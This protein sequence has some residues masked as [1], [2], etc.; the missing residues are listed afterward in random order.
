[1]IVGREDVC[2]TNACDCLSKKLPHDAIV[3]SS[4][5]ASS[6]S[7]HNNSKKNNTSLITQCSSEPTH[8]I[9]NMDTGTT[10]HYFALKDNPILKHVNR[11]TPTEQIQV[12]MPNG[13][14]ITSS[15]TAELNIPELPLEARR[16]HLFPDLQ[17]SLISIGDLCDAVIET[18]PRASGWSTSQHTRPI[19]S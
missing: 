4:F 3:Q 11:A 10:G 12:K 8:H 2:S 15:H 16:V 14:T 17:G 19:H 1:V 9:A 13:P 18:P 6:H 7:I 5:V